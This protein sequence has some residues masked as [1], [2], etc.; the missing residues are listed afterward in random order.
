[1]TE[2][3]MRLIRPHLSENIPTRKKREED[4]LNA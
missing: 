4:R 1:M 2:F 3:R